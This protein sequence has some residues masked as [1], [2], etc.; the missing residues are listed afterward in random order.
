[1]ETIISKVKENLTFLFEK[2]KLTENISKISVAFSGGRD[3]VVLLNILLQL[4]NIFNLDISCCYINHN[5]RGEESFDEENFVKSYCEKLNVKLYALSVSSDYWNKIGRD[6]I[7]MAARKVRYDFFYK[8]VKENRI[9]YIA[10]AHHLND[11]IE[12][13]FIQMLR[14]GGIETLTSIPLKN[15]K[16]IRPLINVKRE[17]IDKFIL[18]NNLPFIE[19]STNNKNIYKRNIVRN[20]LIPILKEINPGF[21]K[22]IVNLFNI[23]EEETSLFNK[24]TEASYKDLIV[25][26][27]RNYICIDRAEYI[28]NEI[29]V[30]KYILKKILKKLGYPTKPNKIL[31]KNLSSDR[32]KFL[33]SKENFYCKSLGNYIWFINTKNIAV[34]NRTFI[35][36]NIP[37]KKNIGGDLF[38]IK[39]D[40][41]SNPKDSF[42]FKGEIKLPIKMRRLL[43]DDKL[44]ISENNKKKIIKMLKDN[45]I[46]SILFEKIIIFESSEKEIIGYYLNKNFF[47]ID[48][49]FYIKDFNEKNY[50]FYRN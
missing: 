2:N 16:I 3:S 31:L 37:F 13:F 49:K 24:I 15:G 35:I 18:E 46:P 7:E 12:T 14:T 41:I 33:Y 17:E 23:I 22:S 43:S 10:A 50:I 19:D 30:R 4:K 20:K 42:C 39:K 6:S 38:Y 11:K 9:N 26:E 27:N 28:G 25:C 45:K 44:E 47:R 1:M 21:E 40:I 32:E 29:A 8:I 48:K 36:K 5:L 34:M